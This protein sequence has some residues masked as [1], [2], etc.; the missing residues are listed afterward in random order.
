MRAAADPDSSCYPEFY[1]EKDV[2]GMENVD[3]R[4]WLQQ[5][6]KRCKLSYALD[7]YKTILIENRIRRIEW[8]SLWAPTITQNARNRVR[9]RSNSALSIA[10]NGSHLALS[11]HPV[12]L[13]LRVD[14]M[15]IDGPILSRP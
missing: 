5:S 2:W 3:F 1:T 12:S 4:T 13:L 14:A 6:Q 15:R 10:S 11:P 7:Q 9:N 8:D